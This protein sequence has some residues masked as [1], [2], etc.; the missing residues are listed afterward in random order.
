VTTNLIQ[1]E[2]N[3]LLV[4]S[5]SEWFTAIERLICD[6]E[7]RRRIAANA[8]NTIVEHY[9]LQVW[10]PRLVDLFNTLLSRTQALPA[11]VAA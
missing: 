1:H 6:V 3:G 11:A 9:S 10:G 7:L 2:V 8:R 4:G 5:S